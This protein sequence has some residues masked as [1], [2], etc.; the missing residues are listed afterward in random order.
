LFESFPKDE[1][2]QA[3]AGELRRLISGL[4]QLERHGGI[5]V[6]VRRDLYGRSISSWWR[7]RGTG[8]TPACAR[9][10]RTCSRTRFHGSTVDYHLS[11]GE[12]ENAR[13]FFTVHVD[14]GVQIPEVPYEEL[15]QDVERLARTWDDD[16]RDALVA[17]VGAERGAGARGSLRA[18]VPG[19]LQ[20]QPR[21][22]ADRRRTSSSSTRWSRTTK[23]S[24]SGSATSRRASV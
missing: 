17:R 15:E 2:F 23:G 5:R 3:S 16:L 22:G 13:I 4:L 19:V 20:V 14:P 6:L 10:C 11:L 12:T 21:L 7:S 18:A 1:L 8:S 24:S 9:A